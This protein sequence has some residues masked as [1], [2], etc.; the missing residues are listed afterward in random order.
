MRQMQKEI[1]MLQDACR[2]I[3]AEVW[4]WLQDT[5]I[6]EG[7]MSCSMV[8]MNQ[9]TGLLSDDFWTTCLRVAHACADVS[10]P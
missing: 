7:F 4:S 1:K 2:Y 3:A 9:C 10:K 6:A 8:E 5:G